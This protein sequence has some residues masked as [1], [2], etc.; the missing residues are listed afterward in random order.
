[1]SDER[2]RPTALEAF[3]P[4]VFMALLLG[5]G[6]GVYRLR[7]E[8]LLIAAAAV[9]G[10]VAV[11]LGYSWAELQAGI[12]E[13]IAKALPAALILVCV[14]A[15]ISTWIAGGTIPLLLMLGLHT[16]SPRFFLVTACVLCSFVSLFTGTSWGTVGTMGIALM[17][18]AAGLGVPLGAAAGAIVAGAYFGDKLSPFS[19]TTNLAPVAAQSN[20]F[21]HIRH[22]LW[23][24]APA[25]TLGLLVYLVVG[26]RAESAASP[27]RV[28]AILD[29]LGTAFV[30]SPWV[31]LPLPVVLYFAV[32]QRPTI[33]G[34]LLASALA[35]VMALIFQGESLSDVAEAAVSGYVADTGDPAVDGLLSR[36]G[37]GPM[38]EVTLIVFAA[39]SFAGI[40]NRAGLLD[41]ALGHLMRLTRTTG[42]LVAATAGSTIFTALITGSSYL[43]ILMPGELFAPAYRARQLAAK[44]LSRTLE[45]SGTVVVPLIPWSAAGV[46]MAATLDVPTLSYLP[47]AVMNYT[48]FLFAILYGFSGFA[49]APR[50]REDETLPG[51]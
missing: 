15:L 17:G 13:G 19:D 32:R 34:I 8:V 39:F 11:R 51:S 42:Q 5:V 6:Y 25:W 37:M 9:A 3:L 26:L 18:V 48:G 20:L 24:T 43:T 4:F 1:M 33:P 22:M 50:V 45:D 27:E 16:I 36:G 23:T 31:L 29:T 40:A 30:M 41:V 7:I 35:G 10:L 21:D 47:W 2:R 14:G 38:M 12:I 49:I 46:F 28:A 44:N